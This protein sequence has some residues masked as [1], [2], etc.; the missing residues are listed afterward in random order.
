MHYMRRQTYQHPVTWVVVDD[1]NPR[2][3]D[4]LQTDFKARWTILKTYPTPTWRP[5]ENT[6]GRN[7]NAAINIILHN[8]QLSDV[9]C[10]FFIEDD[11]YY[12]P[13]YLERMMQYWDGG[14]LLAET[15]TIYYNALMRH[16]LVN[17]NT[18]HGS[19]FQTAMSPLAIPYLKKVLHERFIDFAL[20]RSTPGGKLFHEY[21]LA[22][23]IKGLPG[24][25]GIGGGH[26][27][28]PNGF[29]RDLDMRFL[30]YKIGDEDAKL[31]EGYYRPDGLPQYGQLN[32][33]RR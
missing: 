11:D 1:C 2:T 4:D 10:I 9:E 16:Y 32:K 8:F 20:W 14:G 24:R 7:L 23:G 25:G 21:D 33:R 15:N 18:A 13:E 6:Q 26:A 31:Y 5:G 29:M 12:R 17:A 28:V 27:T 3:T 19:L 22:V 30:K